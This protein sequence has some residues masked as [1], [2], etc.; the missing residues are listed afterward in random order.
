MI[1]SKEDLRAYLKADQEAYGKPNHLFIKWLTRSDEYY[2]R[3]FMVALRYYEY[4]LNKKRNVFDMIPYLFWWWNHRRLKL[5]SQLY[6]YPNVVDAGFFPVHAG[7]MRFG[8]YIH[9][10]RN[11]K[12]LPMVLIGK[13][14]PEPTCSITIGDN[15]FINTGATILGPVTIGNN[16]TIGAGAVV[17]KDIPDDAIVAGVPAKVIKYKVKNEE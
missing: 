8:K 12:V 15:C 11:C 17:T 3:A 5:K 1:Q 13:K 9:V 6:I 7:F 2:I 14:N 16:V 10:G 4:Y